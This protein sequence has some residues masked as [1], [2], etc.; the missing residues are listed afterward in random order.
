MTTFE[1]LKNANGAK[2]SV[3]MLSG[4]QKDSALLNMADEL[5]ESAG[6]ILAANAIDMNA[7]RGIIS[8]VMLDRLALSQ[9]R[10]HAMAEGLRAVAK[11]PDPVGEVREEFTRPN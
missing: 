9:D 8:D 1:I 2:G 4:E 3:A 7:A 6:E 11:L 5:E 10:I